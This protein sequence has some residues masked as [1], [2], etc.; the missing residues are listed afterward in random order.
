MQAMAV[1]TERPQ[2]RVRTHVTWHPMHRPRVGS[3]GA[4]RVPRPGSGQRDALVRGFPDIPD[5][6]GSY[7]AGY[8]GE[9]NT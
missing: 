3:D 6:A 7:P 5:T 8:G 1:A 4:G 9:A 2:P